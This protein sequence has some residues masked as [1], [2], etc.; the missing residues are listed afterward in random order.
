ME[1]LN[2]V[3][4]LIAK[5]DELAKL[6]K[7]LEAEVRKRACDIDNLDAAMALFDLTQTRPKPS[8]VTSQSTA[9]RK[10]AS[11]HS[12]SNSSDGIAQF[13]DQ[14]ECSLVLVKA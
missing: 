1:R 2:A 12:W 9:P 13:V 7:R 5:R 8:N 11:R 3:S 4:G 10:A 6:R 14:L